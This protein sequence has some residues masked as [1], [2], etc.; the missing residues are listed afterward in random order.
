MRFEEAYEEWNEGRLTQVAAA[1]LMHA[2]DD[3]NLSLAIEAESGIT[4]GVRGSRRRN[5]KYHRKE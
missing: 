3:G 4:G 5:R 1:R 2:A